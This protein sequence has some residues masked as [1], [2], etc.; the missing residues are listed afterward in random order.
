M[1]KYILVYDHNSECYDVITE[2]EYLKSKQHIEYIKDGD[3]FDVLNYEADYKNGEYQ[4]YD[5]Y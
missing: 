3:D 4:Y 5:D 2:K 1:R